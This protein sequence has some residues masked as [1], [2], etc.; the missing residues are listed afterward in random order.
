MFKANPTMSTT[1]RCE[2]IGAPSPMHRSEAIGSRA[3]VRDGLLLKIGS[4]TSDAMP[5]KLCCGDQ[6]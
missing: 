1:R 4:R 3:A 2:V 5:E 6:L